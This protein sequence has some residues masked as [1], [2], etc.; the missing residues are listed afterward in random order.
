[1]K[2]KNQT[3]VTEF[4]LLGFSD[5]SRLQNLLFVAFFVMYILTVLGNI[6]IITVVRIDPQLQTPMYYFLSNL[7]FVDICYSSTITP[8]ALVDFKVEENTISL[9]ECAMQLFMFV[10]LAATECLL[11]AVM[12]YD[13]YVAICNP[14]H[15]TV[16]MTRTVCTQLMIGVYMISTVYS[17]IQTVNIFS[18]N[19]C[20][21]NEINHFYCDAHPL[22]KLSCSDTSSNE[23]VLS[24]FGGIYCFLSVIAIVLSYIFIISAILRM[25]SSKSIRKAFSTCGSHF[26]T[27]IIF[28]GTI[29]FIYVIPSS[30]FSLYTNRVL[31][32]IYTMVIPMVNPMIYSLRNKDVKR[33]LRKV[34]ETKWFCYT[35]NF[36]S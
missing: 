1:M 26:I 20:G 3:S 6:S 32:V 14:L 28:F 35:N 34:L 2:G 15:Y 10:T 9:L 24:V 33:A 29:I 8:K 18:V 19:F 11:L 12:A 22:L 31:S 5:L 7:S 27:V 17:L 13:R 4:I 16:V 36:F 21:S 30:F 23:I 25:R